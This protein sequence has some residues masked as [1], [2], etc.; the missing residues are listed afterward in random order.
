VGGRCEYVNDLMH[1]NDVVLQ[2]PVVNWTRPVC[3]E[4]AVVNADVLMFLLTVRMTTSACVKTT[5]TAGPELAV[6]II[7]Y[8]CIIYNKRTFHHF[9]VGM[10]SLLVYM[11]FSKFKKIT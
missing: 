3:L 5:P 9:Y 4:W 8:A 11:T 6:I 7:I 2:F 1:I 10:L